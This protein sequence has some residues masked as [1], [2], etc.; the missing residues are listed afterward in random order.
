MK[1][2]DKLKEIDQDMYYMLLAYKDRY[3]TEFQTL[4][5]QQSLWDCTKEQITLWVGFVTGKLQSNYLKQI[6][7]KL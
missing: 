1:P 5:S 3:Y 6:E 4:T 2:A 7:P